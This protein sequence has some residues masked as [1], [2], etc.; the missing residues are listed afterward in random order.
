MVKPGETKEE[1]LPVG[2][3]VCPQSRGR[4]SQAVQ[5]DEHTML[6][7]KVNEPDRRISSIGDRIRA[8]GR[9]QENGRLTVK[10]GGGR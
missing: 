5:S 10:C 3:A 2:D 1:C 8:S 7:E 6:T 9:L 4:K